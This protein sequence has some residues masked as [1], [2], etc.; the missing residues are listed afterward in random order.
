MRVQKKQ[1]Q[2]ANLEK[3]T[4]F[5]QQKTAKFPGISQQ[6]PEQNC[7]RSGR[8]Q[9]SPRNLYITELLR[10]YTFSSKPP[11]SEA[12]LELADNRRTS[13]VEN[14]ASGFATSGLLEV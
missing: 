6:R 10:L 2:R 12:F 8:D 1:R 7:H 11:Y 9:T 14:N 5:A 13:Y 3:Q 4:R